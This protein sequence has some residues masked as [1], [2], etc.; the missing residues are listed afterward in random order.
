MPWRHRL[1]YCAGVLNHFL[2]EFCHRTD[3]SPVGCSN[4]PETHPHSHRPN[5]DCGTGQRSRRGRTTARTSAPTCA[6][7][8]TEGR[9][10]NGACARASTA[11]GGRPEMTSNG[12]RQSGF[13]I[14]VLMGGGAQNPS[15]KRRPKSRRAIKQWR[16]KPPFQS[17]L[18][19]A[20]GP[21]AFFSNCIGAGRLPPLCNAGK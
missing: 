15:A 10:G 3:F 18:C 16:R 19:G 1:A 4:P 13:F 14:N 7:A 17:R 2:L 8:W 5:Q 20:F 9:T 12:C 6:D 21:R 11:T